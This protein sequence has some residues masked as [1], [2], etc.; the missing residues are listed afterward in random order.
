MSIIKKP[1]K[2]IVWGLSLVFG[3]ALVFFVR[4]FGINSLEKKEF[5]RVSLLGMAGILQAHADV[6]PGDGNG[7][8]SDGDSSGGY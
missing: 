4:V 5:S 8:G 1:V 7:D 6:P 3:L 2:K